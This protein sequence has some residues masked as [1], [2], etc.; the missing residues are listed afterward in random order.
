MKQ[1]TERATDFI[2]RKAAQ[3]F[4]LE[5]AY[6]MPHVPLHVS[7]SFK[8]KS[9]VGLYG[10][11][12]LEIDWSVGEIMKPSTRPR[13]LTTLSLSSPAITALG[14]ATAIMP[15]ARGHS[16][17]AKDRMDGGVRV[18]CVM[19]WPRQNSRGQGQRR[20]ANDD[21]SLA[22]DYPSNRWQVARARDRWP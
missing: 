10:D 5:V 18:P 21:R 22:D 2:K 14:S 8:G 20:T 17:K 12:L 15:A 13:L 1:Y 4:F 16:A 19:R 11:V 6:A 3:P 9:G 7:E